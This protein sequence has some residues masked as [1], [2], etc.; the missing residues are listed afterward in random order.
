MENLDLER[1]L[2]IVEDNE[3]IVLYLKS[4][5]EKEYTVW[6]AEDGRQGLQLALEKMPNIIISDI[7]MPEMDGFEFCKQLKANS[8]TSHIPIIFL[9]AK[10][11]I[12]SK[13][14]GLGLGATDYIYKPFLA[15]ELQ[16]KVNSLNQLQSNVLKFL[17]N[18]V[19][20]NK[21]ALGDETIERFI[22]KNKSNAVLEEEFLQKIVDVVDAN[23]ANPDFDVEHFALKLF[24]SPVQLRRKIKAV[25]NFTIVEFIR[26]YRLKKAEVL[27]RNNN[28]N[29]SEVAY[30]VGFDSLSYFSRVFQEYYQKSPTAYRSTL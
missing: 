9:T 11:D 15:Q 26:N 4:I 27:I 19:L 3:D 24:I 28:V 23:Y 8:K 18:K 30:S 1:V 29:I 13:L 16:V 6:E 7:M 20:E 5:F 25:T 2:L 17:S 10:T 21:Y 12:E 22:N 14:I